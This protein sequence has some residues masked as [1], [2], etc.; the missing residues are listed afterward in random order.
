MKRIILSVCIICSVGLYAMT[1]EP[2]KRYSDRVNVIEDDSQLVIVI[3]TE[4]EPNSY[5]IYEI[6]I[7]GARDEDVIVLNSRDCSMKTIGDN[8]ILVISGFTKKFEITGIGVM[9][10]RRG[11]MEYYSM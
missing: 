5:D 10:I 9:L 7:F 11:K 1:R 6:Y 8:L 2:P 3:A 4:F